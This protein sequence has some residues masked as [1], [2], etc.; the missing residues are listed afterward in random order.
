[1]ISWL[2]IIPLC[3]WRVQDPSFFI[4]GVCTQQQNLQWTQQSKRLKKVGTTSNLTKPT[5][6]S[7][8]IRRKDLRQEQEENTRNILKTFSK[9]IL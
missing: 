4:V 5:K 3:R 1:M 8:Q 9:T 7:E 2:W 6:N